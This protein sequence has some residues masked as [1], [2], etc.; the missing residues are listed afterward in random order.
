GSDLNVVLLLRPGPDPRPLGPGLPE[1]AFSH[2]RGLITKAEVRAVA[3]GLLRLPRQGVLWDVGAGSGSLAVEACL[4]AP[5][6]QAYAVEK[7]VAGLGHIRENRRR[8][9]VAGLVPV[10]GVAPEALGDL[11]DPDCV[12]V[13]GSGG[14]LAEILDTCRARLRPGG[15]LVVSAVLTETLADT[16]AWC[17]ERAVPVSFREVSASRSK[18]VAGRHRLEPQNPVTLVQIGKPT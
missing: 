14:N 7:T 8:F 10:A 6:L 5:G 18:P 4:A 11:P 16:L 9:R 13:G 12:F 3:L 1:A 2:A 17:R 15:G